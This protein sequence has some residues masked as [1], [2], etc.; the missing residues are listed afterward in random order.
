MKK[1]SFLFLLSLFGFSVLNDVV[2]QNILLEK[3]R[4]IYPREKSIFIY[5]KKKVNID[6]DVK[7][8]SFKIISQVESHMLHLRLHS[9]AYA[10]EAITYS[11]YT[12]IS[13][14]DAYSLVKMTDG[15]KKKQVTNFQTR[16]AV[17]EDVFYNDVKE[18]VFLFPNIIAGTQTHLAYTEELLEPRFLG[19]FFFTSY[20][21]SQKTEFSVSVANNIEIGFQLF[22]MDTSTIIFTEKREENRKIYTWVLE[23][24]PKYTDENSSPNLRYYEPHIVL[25]I[26][27]RII[28]G[29]NKKTIP[30]SSSV[31]NLYDWYYPFIKEIDTLKEFPELEYFVDELTAND[32]TE[33]TKAKRI[34]DWISTQVQYIA[35]EDGERGFRPAHPKKVCQRKYGDCKD[36][37]SALLAMLRVEGIEAYFGWLG[38]RDLPYTYA[39]TPVPLVDN[40]MIVVAKINGK[41]YFLDATGSQ[42]TFGTP[43]YFTQ[44]KEVLVAIDSNTFEVLTVDSAPYSQNTVYDS[45]KVKIEGANIIVT[46]NMILKG[47]PKTTII[48]YLNFQDKE[49]ENKAFKHLLNPHE[50]TLQ[51]KKIEIVPTKRKKPL[52]INYEY[53]I[54]NHTQSLYSD[55]YI[56]LHLNPVWRNTEIDSLRKT[57]VNANYKFEKTQVYVLELPRGTSIKHLPQNQ[58]YDSEYFGFSVEYTRSSEQIIL[59]HTVYSNYLILPVSEYNNWNEMVKQLHQAYRQNIV[60]QR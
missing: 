49:Q 11:D 3:N 28:K 10:Q 52:Q 41:N 30:L 46:G 17:S 1:Y 6:F 55:F 13:N 35:F 37:A 24:A 53:E 42:E 51:L 38:S 40:H 12:K 39:Q 27:N 31:K 16:D 44:N 5:R 8:D 29:N 56:N 25:F 34:F 60:L 26:K 47:F 32:T 18:K 2:S 54:P 4:K 45:A 50:P 15:V 48:P 57:P 33:L 20:I 21:P 9:Q 43:S 58:N 36:M 23:K 59:K 22:G 19:S 7:K 14:I